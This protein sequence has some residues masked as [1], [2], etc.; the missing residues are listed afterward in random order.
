[1]GFLFSLF[2][3]RIGRTALVALVVVAAVGYLRYDAA[4]DA[5]RDAEIAFRKAVE[6]QTAAEVRRQRE[7]AARAV[8]AAEAHAEKMKA[9]RDALKKKV[10]GIVWRLRSDPDRTCTLDDELLRE[11]RAIE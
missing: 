11:L 1:M 5:R 8:G 2:A 6:Q 4:Q 10:D 9:E 3:S 7:A